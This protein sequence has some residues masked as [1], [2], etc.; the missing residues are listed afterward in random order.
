MGRLSDLHRGI[1]AYREYEPVEQDDDSSDEVG[2]DEVVE[3]IG[4]VTGAVSGLSAESVAKEI[5][6]LRGAINR[7]ING[8]KD[9]PQAEAVTLPDSFALDAK[10]L[11]KAI[12]ALV[13]TITAEKPKPEPVRYE[14]QR[15]AD[16]LMTSVVVRPDRPE[17]AKPETAVFE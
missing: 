12:Q 16:G 15:N 10:S 2:L 14:I 4:K 9:M 17:K 13:E 6:Q 1:Q 3:S 7:L 5:K 11:E 8:I